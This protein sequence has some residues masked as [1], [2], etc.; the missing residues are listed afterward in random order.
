MEDRDEARPQ[1][2]EE[3]LEET[4]R[5][6]ADVA[7]GSERAAPPSAIPDAERAE[8]LDVPPPEEEIPREEAPLPPLVPERPAPPRMPPSPPA[9]VPPS[10]RRMAAS[11]PPSGAAAEAPRRSGCAPV[12][13]VLL[14]VFL[15]LV[16]GAVAARL[17]TARS[18]LAG[19]APSSPT[20]TLAVAPGHCLDWTGGTLAE[21]TGR[22][23]AATHEYEIY[24]IV[25]DTAL[26]DAGS[27]DAA[28]DACL[29]DFVR[30]TGTRYDDSPYWLTYADLPDGSGIACLLY[31]GD[32][33]G[34]MVPSEGSAAG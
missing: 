33:D 28:Y 24:A 12:A 32:R 27:P 16:G 1:S 4:K 17:I 9:R 34:N 30:Y 6:L 25:L 11:T 14:L 18:R 26:V 3:L 2:S 23:C 21:A 22:S 20:V 8:L 7:P 31:L 13:T 10:P 5:W 19:P 15:G 29:P